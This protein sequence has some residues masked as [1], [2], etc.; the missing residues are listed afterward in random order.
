MLKNLPGN[1][2]DVRDVGLIPGS[3]RSSGEGN[4][5]LFQN[6]CLENPVD[7]GIRQVIVHGVIKELDM[8]E[9]LKKESSQT[10]R[11]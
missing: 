7:K 1:A 2:G 3:G 8:T 4:G 9:R 11:S 6:S 5:N 10:H